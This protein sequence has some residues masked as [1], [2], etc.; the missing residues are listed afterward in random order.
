MNFIF[1]H[2]DEF[3]QHWQANTVDPDKWIISGF[4]SA[5][6]SDRIGRYELYLHG[7]PVASSDTLWEMDYAATQAE[8]RRQRASV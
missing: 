6:G 2:A 4:F 3:A 1:S 5:P 8:A 7:R